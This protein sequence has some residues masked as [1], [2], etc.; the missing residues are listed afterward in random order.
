[1]SKAAL[2]LR[3]VKSNKFLKFMGFFLNLCMFYTFI[4]P[5]FEYACL[6]GL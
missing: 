4:P 2:K 3:L 6:T 1:M 5:V